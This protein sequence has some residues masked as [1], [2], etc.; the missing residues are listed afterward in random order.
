CSKDKDLEQLLGENV[1]MFDPKKGE[2]VDVG[3]LF[4]KKGL[5]PDQVIDLLALQGD[6]SDNVPGVADV[7]PK[8]ALQWLQKYGSLD[9][10]LAH[11]DEIKGKRGDNLRA[12]LEQLALSRKLVTIDREV[13]IEFDFGEMSLKPFNLSVL[14]EIFGELGFRKLSAQLDKLPA[15]LVQGSDGAEMEAAVEASLVPT[16]I[17]ANYVLVDTPG[18]WA[19][20]LGKLNQQKVFALD[21]ETTSVNP[22]A[23]ELVGLSFSW[24]GGEGYYL[25]VKGPLGAVFLDRQ[26]VLDELSPI[27]SDPKIKIIGQNIK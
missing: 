6:T 12:G 22:V 18:A 17:E 26:E 24:Q 2:E 11:K 20:F 15:D 14:D 8:T 21:T 19:D 7:G 10:L 25:P 3:G 1:L 27:L 16:E 4:E 9:E 23:A 13:P 5:R